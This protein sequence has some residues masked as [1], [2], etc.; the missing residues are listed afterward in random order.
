[1]IPSPLILDLSG[2]SWP[3]GAML[4]G[5]VIM[6]QPPDG[7]AIDASF[8]LPGRKS[9]QA[10]AYISPYTEMELGTKSLSDH[11]AGELASGVQSVIDHPE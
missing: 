11:V 9:I 4:I 6:P 10:R 7:L 3:G 2:Y 1:M 8:A 5:A